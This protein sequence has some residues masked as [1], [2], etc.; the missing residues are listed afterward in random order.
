MKLEEG[1]K[2]L[3]LE[4]AEVIRKKKLIKTKNGTLDHVEE[5]LSDEIANIERQRFEVEKN[6]LILER[7]KFELEKSEFAIRKIE[8][9]MEQNRDLPSLSAIQENGPAEEADVNFYETKDI[10]Q[11]KNENIIS[12]TQIEQRSPFSNHMNNPATSQD[13]TTPYGLNIDA[14]LERLAGKPDEPTVFMF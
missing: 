9:E 3:E 12:E 7:K 11:P 6:Q 14:S 8:L 10:D 2:N 5:T 4:L 1:N 13:S